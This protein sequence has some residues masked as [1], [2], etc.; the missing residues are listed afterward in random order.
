MEW[1]NLKRRPEIY[2]NLNSEQLQ[3][4][5]V[6]ISRYKRSSCTF[7]WSGIA[8]S[9]CGGWYWLGFINNFSTRLNKWDNSLT[10][11]LFIPEWQIGE[12]YVLGW[13]Y[14]VMSE[15]LDHCLKKWGTLIYGFP[16]KVKKK[17]TSNSLWL[18]DISNNQIKLA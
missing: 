15:S 5:K 11:G 10:T 16:I 4:L 14:R 18:T 1:P 17:F 6:L 9:I 8:G 7:G 2:I 3:L 12:A 13:L